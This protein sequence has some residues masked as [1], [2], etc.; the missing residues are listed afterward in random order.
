MS[1]ESRRKLLKSIAVGTGA[2]VAGK[3]LPDMWSRPVVESVLLPA[4]AQTSAPAA[5]IP[6]IA[7]VFTTGIFVVAEQSSSNQSFAANNI[8]SSSNLLSLLLKDA[9]ADDRT[10]VQ[11]CDGTTTTGDIT[12]TY[13][14]PAGPLPKTVDVCIESNSNNSGLCRQLQ[15]TTMATDSTLGDL[16]NLDIPR[17]NP[18][19]H[20]LNL[21][22]MSVTLS[23]DIIGNVAVF[24]QDRPIGNCNGS[25]TATAT[26]SA[27]TC[28]A[29]CAL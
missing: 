18:D 9:R 4:H 19:V 20:Q 28:T 12:I 16:L 11:L 14:V 7:G 25:F 5:L 6:L 26:A 27:F 23:G 8:D 1:N 17:N 22:G 2:V 29:D 3:S 24:D 13:N 21:S 15:Q 10:A